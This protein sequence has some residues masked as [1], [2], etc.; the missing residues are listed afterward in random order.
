MLASPT[1]STNRL[2]PFI[3]TRPRRS[4][5]GDPRFA[6]DLSYLNEGGYR[7]VRDED[8]VAEPQVIGTLPVELDG[9]FLRSG[10]NAM[11][12][13]PAGGHLFAGAPMIHSVRLRDGRAQWYRNRYVR[14]DAVSRALGTLPAPGP[15]NGF[16]DDVNA[17][18]IHHAGRTLAVGDGGALPYEIGPQLETLGRT[19]LDGTLPGGLSAHPQVDSMTGEL[20][21]A[22]FTPQSPC[23]TLLTI[24]TDGRVTR[25][26]QLPMPGISM[27]HAFSITRQYA[28]LYDL[29]VT[30]GNGG[31]RAGYR[32]D[33]DHGARLCIVPRS[34]GAGDVRRIE[35]E[36][37][38]VFHPVNA[39]EVGSDRIVVDV[40]R[41]ERA[42]DHDALRPSESRPALWRWTVDLRA[43]TVAEQQLSEHCEEFP[44]MDDRFKGQAARYAFG[45]QMHRSGLAGDALL[46]HD[47]RTGTTDV[48][49]VGPGQETGEAVF[50]P[51]GPSAPE[52][53]GWLLS[54]VYN[55]VHD[56]SE[57]QVIDTADFT[58]DPVAVVRLPVR[59][60]HGFHST[61]IPT[62]S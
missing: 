59:V 41:H 36:P 29:P 26:T 56:R 11:G 17:N 60:P 55:A 49:P 14:T 20:V 39:Y 30:Y 16:F 61:W 58:G 52:A 45:V 12:G 4:G 40:V 38:Y 2:V 48:H 9:C 10:P 5:L 46:R 21:A 62:G 31:A 53:D 27:M 33:D 43:G 13:R 25:S 19:D 34:G 44:R 57:V 35:I 47:L 32:W 50:V 6:A 23:V 1:R 8:F 37:A 42:F 7:P 3:P 28:V 22:T 51:R 15:R 54:M 24:G 18:V